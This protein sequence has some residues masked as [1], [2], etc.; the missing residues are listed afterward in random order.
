MQYKGADGRAK[1]WIS[2]HTSTVFRSGKDGERCEQIMLK[3]QVHKDAQKRDRGGKEEISR[4]SQS[5]TN[6]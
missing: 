6:M 1:L 4:G 3:K 2:V 5:T